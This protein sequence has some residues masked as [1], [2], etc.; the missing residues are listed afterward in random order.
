ML[1]TIIPDDCSQATGYVWREAYGRDDHICVPPASRTQAVEDN[2]QAGRRRAP[3]SDAC[4][5]GFVWREADQSDKHRHDHVCVTPA[6]KSQTIEDNKKH[7]IRLNQECLSRGQ[8]PF[9]PLLGAVN[10]PSRQP[11]SA[12][13]Y[14][15]LPA[16]AK[17]DGGERG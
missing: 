11:P 4:Q 15:E 5:P 13:R 3:G 8:S 6:T 1:L 7:S 17:R 16:V 10:P 14:D 2:A 9:G 12:M